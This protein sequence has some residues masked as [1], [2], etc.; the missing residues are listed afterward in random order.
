MTFEITFIEDRIPA[1]KAGEYQIQVT[2]SVDANG[3]SVDYVARRHFQVSGPRFAL[4]STDVHARFPGALASGKYL[5]CL[6]HIV[7]NRAM[8][9]WLRSLSTHDPATSGFVALLLLDPS[10]APAIENHQ[11][12]DLIPH[13][14]TVVTSTPKTSSG[15]GRLPSHILSYGFNRPAVGDDYELEYGERPTDSLLTI[16]LPANL[17][18]EVVPSRLDMPY[19]SHV[20]QVDVSGHIAGVGRGGRVPGHPDLGHYA[21][22]IG[23]RLPAMGK[24]LAVLVSLEGLGASL[25]SGSGGSNLGA[26]DHAV[27]LCV[28][29][30]WTFTATGSGE[31]LHHALAHLNHNPQD[32]A[33]PLSTLAIPATAPQRNSVLAA[34]RAQKQGEITHEQADVLA[35]AAL[36]QGYV[37]FEHQ[38]RIGSSS[39]SWYRG[40]LAGPSPPLALT[41]P[42][43]NS[44]AALRYDPT[45]G[46]FDVSYA[47]AWQ[48]GQLL[49]LED[50][51]FHQAL[52]EWQ[53]AVRAQQTVA[54]DALS[55]A[56][57]RLETV[58]DEDPSPQACLSRVLRGSLTR[59]DARDADSPPPVVD[60]F[61]N[62]LKH[63]KSIPFHYL[64]P[65]ERMLPAE[66][67]RFFHLDKNWIN[68]L[69]CGAGSVAAV[70]PSGTPPVA[71]WLYGSGEGGAV[72]GLLLRSKVVHDYPGLI[73]D[74]SRGGQILHPLQKTLLSPSMLLILV[75][76]ELDKVTLHQPLEVLHFGVEEQGSHWHVDL[77]H[78]KQQTGL[79]IYH[80]TP[81]AEV[82]DALGTRTV[83]TRQNNFE[84]RR[85]QTPD[86]PSVEETPYT[87]S[88]SFRS[89]DPRTVDLATTAQSIRQALIQHQALTATDPFTSAEFA[90]EMV[91]NVVKV[92]FQLAQ[93]T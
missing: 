84:E 66:S 27:R 23:N 79:P 4:Q 14:R 46:L 62:D 35:R 33:S 22:T 11:I 5:N 63:L 56:L 29:D 31:A 50:R 86:A 48:L 91:K 80:G 51:A 41:S 37:P 71:H 39:I 74:C 10:S 54:L 1:L 49:G 42:I 89:S 12:V 68:A 34:A 52:Y 26:D 65:N 85:W 81:Q 36:C 69:L 78:I 60:Q 59:L 90:L 16:D 24:N 82:S 28:L 45:T 47:A 40:P 2:Q 17:F 9:P 72:T 58:S 30:H 6:P 3:T 67:M 75:E 61:F 38:L 70:D 8:F 53:V 88:V 55:D 25:P 92:E 57:D 21:V 83:E 32:Q 43:E 7:Y 76:G 93:S 18:N 19:V 15:T 87:A 77:R 44:D 13:G 20:R 64:V 73:I